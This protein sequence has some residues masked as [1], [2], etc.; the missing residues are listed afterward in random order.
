MPSKNEVQLKNEELPAYLDEAMKHAGEGISKEADDN[1]VPLASVLQ[2]LSPQVDET[3]PSYVPGA[4]AGDIF[5][6]SHESPVMKGSE[7]VLFQPCYNYR[8]WVEWRTRDT[9][10]GFVMRYPI[11]PQ[12]KRECPVGDAT[13]KPDGR[14]VRPNG[15]EVLETRYVVGFICI[16]SQG[17][18]FVIPFTSTGHTVARTWNTAMNHR[19]MPNG[20]PWPAYTQVWRLKTRQRKNSKGA[21][22]VLEPAFERMATTAEYARGLKMHDDF[23]TGTKAMEDFESQED[24]DEV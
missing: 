4:K 1:L 19:L 17:L 2:A 16:G 11:D 20:Q 8:D 14:F 21:W 22:Y 6:K 18:Q 24:D 12:R 23:E 3:N 9:G 5:L 10:G 7:G 15:N 13:Q